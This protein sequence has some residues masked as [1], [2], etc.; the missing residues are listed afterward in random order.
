MKHSLA[1]GI[2]HIGLPYAEFGVLDFFFSMQVSPNVIGL[3]QFRHELRSFRSDLYFKKRTNNYIEEI[4][5][6]LA[7]K[8]TD[9]ES[10]KIEVANKK[11]F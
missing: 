10:F 4:R 8:T 9:W 5:P 3:R 7:N 2:Q 1:S 11:L 6:Y